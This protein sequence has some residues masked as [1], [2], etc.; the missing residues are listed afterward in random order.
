[1]SYPIVLAEEVY[2]SSTAHGSIALETHTAQSSA[3]TPLR[4]DANEVPSR[5][6]TSGT[7]KNT[8]GVSRKSIF[9]LVARLIGKPS[10]SV[11]ATVQRILPS[12]FR[13]CMD[14][15]ERL[16]WLESERGQMILSKRPIL[17]TQDRNGQLARMVAN[18]HWIPRLNEWLYI[19]DH[20]MLDADNVPYGLKVNT[21][22]KHLREQ[23]FRWLHPPHVHP[24]LGQLFQDCDSFMQPALFP[25]KNKYDL[26]I[27]GFTIFPGVVSASLVA[28]ANAAISTMIVNHEDFKRAHEDQF[29]SSQR[30][31]TNYNNHI[32]G[33]N[34]N[35][36]NNY[37][38]SFEDGFLHGPCNDKNVL[39]LYYA[40]PVYSLVED[41]LHNEGVRHK[42]D[43]GSVSPSI[44]LSDRSKLPVQQRVGGAQ[45]AF[46][47]SQPR[48]SGFWDGGG[49]IGA[50]AS[51]GKLG[52]L[53]WH[54]DGLDRGILNS[55][56]LLIGI[57]LS[58]QLADFSGNLC[59][60]AGSHH[61]LSKYVSDYAHCIDAAASSGLSE[62]EQRQQAF[63]LAR[64]NKPDL[65]EPVQIKLS[66]GDVVVVLHRIAHRGGPNYSDS[67]RR[68]VYFRV[69]HKRHVEL[70]TAALDNLW[71]ELEGMQEVLA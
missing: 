43:S 9:S 15:R 1:M 44:T 14:T 51:G 2:S 64:R 61:T 56:T 7:V 42:H 65:G 26:L 62:L 50:A 16:R 18:K 40:S 46:R 11:P 29:S 28:S 20:F 27:D 13:E 35:G 23:E 19:P 49:S 45:V 48:P 69:S 3:Y 24:P 12:Q 57:A 32:N 55:F 21:V 30:T 67:I 53:G 25:T 17:Q 71:V 47:F 54:I 63:E 8:T 33:N 39:A 4:P 38:P 10:S 66:R 70:K 60:H 68:M 5:T 22:P 31:G 58:D 34:G 37:A 36:N 52:G 6:N 59:L 41:I